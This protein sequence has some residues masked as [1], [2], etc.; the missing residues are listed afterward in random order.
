MTSL[1]SVCRHVKNPLTND[2]RLNRLIKFRGFSSNESHRPSQVK[3]GW[4]RNVIS[5]LLPFSS[6]L[7]S[8]RGRPMENIA[9][10]Y[11]IPQPI[12]TVENPLPGYLNTQRRV[13]DSWLEMILPFSD[14]SLL[15]DIFLAA[16]GNSVRYGKLFEILDALAADVAY[17]HCGNS[18]K[19]G[20]K[21]SQTVVTASV[22]GV[23]ASANINVMHDLKLRSYLT[24]VGKSSMEVTID[25]I[26]V[27]H[28]GT[29]IIV[30]DTQFIMVARDP[31]SGKSSK[32]HSLYLD[33]EI[34]KE[35]FDRG[36]KRLA[37]R[38]SKNLTSLS[39]TAPSL[40]EIDIIHKL[41]LASKEVKM[42]KEAI[43][44]SY[45]TNPLIAKNGDQG[46][47]MYI[48]E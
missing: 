45:L 1:F 23:K 37:L 39:K 19:T 15:R 20:E 4:T 27:N 12:I 17:R 18:T 40:E 11:C 6:E 3:M 47:P 42:Q 14:Q 8:V 31:I 2:T 44:N 21:H 29:E 22:D 43:I 48:Y 28:D 13:E 41:Y 46:D 16:D 7:I 10:G 36:K 33:C 38:L 34:A 9:V 32:V 35:K 26:S 30:G 5:E 24:Y 25:M